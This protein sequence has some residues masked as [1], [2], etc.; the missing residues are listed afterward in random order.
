MGFTGKIKTYKNTSEGAGSTVLFSNISS[1]MVFLIHHGGLGG[2]YN[3]MIFV[4]SQSEISVHKYNAGSESDYQ[5]FT[6]SGGMLSIK[7]S[8]YGIGN[9]TAIFVG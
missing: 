2:R 1:G 7:N 8:G 4:K 6:M 9:F 3:A 5:S